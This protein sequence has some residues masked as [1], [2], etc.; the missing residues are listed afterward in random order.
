MY[1]HPKRGEADATKKQ[2]PCP[3]FVRGFCK[4]GDRCPFLHEKKVVCENYMLGFC[5]L[6]PKCKYEHIASVIN[7]EDITLKTLA[8]FPQEESWTDKRL[9]CQ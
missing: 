5:P 8:N 6:G 7:P 3:Y 9:Y 2:E 4:L 1:R